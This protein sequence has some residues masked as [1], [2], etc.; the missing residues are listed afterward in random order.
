M[1]EILTA[2]SQVNRSKSPIPITT[3]TSIVSDI[4]SQ[5]PS[6]EKPDTSGQKLLKSLTTLICKTFNNINIKFD[7]KKRTNQIVP[8]DFVNKYLIEKLIGSGS[9][10]KVYSALNTHTKERVAI[11]MIHTKSDSDEYSR[12]ANRERYFLQELKDNPH[13]V[14][15]LDAFRHMNNKCM[16]FELLASNLYEVTSK[17]KRGFSLETTRK[18]AIQLLTFCESM[19]PTSI[20]S[21]AIHCDLKPENIL[22]Q[23]NTKSRIKIIDFG[24]GCIIGDKT[25]L[26]TQSRYYRAPEVLL[27]LPYSTPVDMWSVGCILYEIYTGKALFPGLDYEDQIKLID[28]IRG[29]IPQDMLDNKKPIKT[30]K[31]YEEDDQ[32]E[33]PDNLQSY[34]AITLEELVDFKQDCTPDFVDLLKQILEIDPNK[35]IK[36]KDA[37]AH[38]FFKVCGIKRKQP[39]ESKASIPASIQLTSI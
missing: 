26:Y 1:T 23:S 24:L 36:P 33:K 38:K 15:L 28:S 32:V 34:P 10:G 12:S 11:K 9:F 31:K 18:F 22:L 8:G 16:V 27:G 2:F 7:E 6:T 39:E 17:I 5:L 21:G 14:K 3:I 25:T 20:F 37:L 29:P 19:Q 35:R 13:V 4:V 30:L